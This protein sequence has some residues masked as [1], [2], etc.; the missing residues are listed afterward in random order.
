MPY[1]RKGLYTE[2]WDVYTD[3]RAAA[4]ERGKIELD[5]EALLS[6]EEFDLEAACQE[7]RDLVAAPLPPLEIPLPPRA[8]AVPPAPPA[9]PAPPSTEGFMKTNHYNID[10][11]NQEVVI[12]T[13]GQSYDYLYPLWGIEHTGNQI[14]LS[15]FWCEIITQRHSLNRWYVASEYVARNHA[16]LRGK[17][18]GAVY[19]VKNARHVLLCKLGGWMTDTDSDIDPELLEDAI[20]TYRYHLAY[21][22]GVQNA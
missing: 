5:F 15:L 10:V 12:V 7:I 2:R 20:T 4:L 19:S 11:K 22:S 21:S 3:A 9:P 1:A 18:I 8:T 17:G 16:K 6:T 13:S 14:E